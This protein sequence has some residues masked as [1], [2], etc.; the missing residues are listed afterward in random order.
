MR[1]FYYRF[2]LGIVWLGTAAVSAINANVPFAALY[3]ILGVVF[4]WSARSIWKKER[5]DNGR[6]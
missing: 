5:S 3:A 4:L 2:I 6:R 1:H